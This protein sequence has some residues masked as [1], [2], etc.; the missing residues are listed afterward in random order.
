[1]E[2]PHIDPYWCVLSICEESIPNGLRI[3]CRKDHLPPAI[4]DLE[5]EC[6]WIRGEKDWSE[7]IVDPIAI[8]REAVRYMDRCIQYGERETACIGT[9]FSCK[10]N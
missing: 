7:S 8:G 9:G 5:L 3:L 6:K 10:G 4:I 1:M 2:F